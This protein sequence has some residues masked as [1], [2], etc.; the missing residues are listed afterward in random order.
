LGLHA[1]HYLDLNEL[2][3][4]PS[5]TGLK[6]LYIYRARVPFATLKKLLSAADGEPSNIVAMRLECVELMDHTWEE[7]FD[8]LTRADAMRYL[9]VENLNYAWCGTSAHLREFNNR[10]WENCSI[11]W[12]ENPPDRH[13]LQDLANKVR[14]AGGVVSDYI[15]EE[16]SDGML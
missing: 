7:V 16:Y 2:G 1:T 3:W 13:R 11:I 4:K 8:H 10:L 6:N 14:A 5:S 9:N 12:T 15:Y